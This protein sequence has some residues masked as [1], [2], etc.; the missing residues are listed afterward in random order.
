[1]CV[2]HCLETDIL[3]NNMLFTDLKMG[4]PFHLFSVFCCQNQEAVIENI[5]KLNYL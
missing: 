3:Q 2:Y 1:M 5:H 4:A